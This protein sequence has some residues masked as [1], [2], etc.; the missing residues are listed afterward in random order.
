MWAY[1]Q[2]GDTMTTI[3][4]FD[5]EAKRIEKLVERYDTCEASIVEAL[6]ELLDDNGIDIDDAMA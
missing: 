2:E 1:A 4:I 5:M 3:E 6:F